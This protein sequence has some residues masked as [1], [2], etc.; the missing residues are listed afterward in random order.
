MTFDPNSSLDEAAARALARMQVSINVD[1]LLADHLTLRQIRTELDAMPNE[2][3]EWFELAYFQ[4]V[5]KRYQEKK[6]PWH[7]VTFFAPS[8]LQQEV[9][10]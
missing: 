2:I 1:A 7:L 9:C 6:A 4:E 8:G 5:G 3:G 10:R